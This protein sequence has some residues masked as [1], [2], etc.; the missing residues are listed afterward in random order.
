MRG[1]AELAEP[2]EV[3]DLGESAARAPALPAS[4]AASVREEIRV[5][6]IVE[7]PRDGRR[8]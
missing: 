3:A 2:A 4:R 7:S 1:I 5:R 6:R 8:R